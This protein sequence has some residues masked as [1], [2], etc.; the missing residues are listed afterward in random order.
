M[1]S[2][3]VGRFSLTL[4][5]QATEP[6]LATF[7][8]G[9]TEPYVF[10]NNLTGQAEFRRVWEALKGNP[11]FTDLVAQFPTLDEWAERLD[12]PAVGESGER[13]AEGSAVAPPPASPPSVPTV[14]E[15]MS[16]TEDPVVAVCAHLKDVVFDAK[17]DVNAS[18]QDHFVITLAAPVPGSQDVLAVRISAYNLATTRGD[19]AGE[20]TIAHLLETKKNI[21]VTFRRDDKGRKDFARFENSNPGI[22]QALLL[23][24][25]AFF[26]DTLPPGLGFE[27]P[28][29]F[30]VEAAV[31]VGEPDVG[32]AEIEIHFKRPGHLK[33]RKILR[34][35]PSEDELSAIRAAVR[36]IRGASSEVGSDLRALQDSL[37]PANF[38]LQEV[39][40]T[41]GPAWMDDIGTQW[42]LCRNDA[43]EKS[44]GY[45]PLNTTDPA[46]IVWELVS[47]A[48]VHADDW[49]KVRRE[50]LARI[51]T[52]GTGGEQHEQ[53]P[54]YWAQAAV[55]LTAALAGL[56]LAA[57]WSDPTVS[58]WVATSLVLFGGFSWLALEGRLAVWDLF[59][60]GAAVAGFKRGEFG[61]VSSG[62][63]PVIL[64]GL[65][66]PISRADLASFLNLILDVLRQS[67]LRGTRRHEKAHLA[68]NAGE[69]RATLESVNASPF[70][71]FL[72][73]LNL[74]AR[75][76]EQIGTRA[77]RHPSLPR[78]FPGV[79][80]AA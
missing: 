47:L 80:C 70:F 71:G 65:E 19:L 2:I 50:M 55:S 3:P 72:A 60:D 37:D 43:S 30:V 35:P 9:G 58:S 59:S 79:L 27:S 62:Q 24:R 22:R 44:L 6:N 5:R 20:V 52:P 76:V 15:P 42:R 10:P 41:S 66:R 12:E 36:Q 48:T 45:F 4:F 64:P 16:T 67:L 28:M 68:R 14:V 40:A 18:G 29:E 61:R 57:F 49:Y 63:V 13:S 75:F 11:I 7:F 34:E 78:I 17:V 53:T 38:V 54:V 21:S 23:A 39:D 32:G 69:L 1:I 77:V 25:A 33:S 26:G 56:A 31:F 46:K 51:N 73:L 8:F 74:P